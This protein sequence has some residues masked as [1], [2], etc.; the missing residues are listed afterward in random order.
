[1]WQRPQTIYMAFSMMMLLAA[2]FFPAFSGELAN[3][4]FVDVFFGHTVER[5]AVTGMEIEARSTFIL[6]AL[7][8]ISILDI[9]TSILLY[10]NRKLQATLLYLAIGF[11]AA[12]L[13]LPGVFYANEAERFAF[14]SVRGGEVLVLASIILTWMAARL[15]QKDEKLVRGSRDRL[16]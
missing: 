7:M 3:G 8:I 1:M 6:M 5:Q 9:A 10:K 13:L 15:V 11:Q 4:N 12:C 2:L 16:R 14:D